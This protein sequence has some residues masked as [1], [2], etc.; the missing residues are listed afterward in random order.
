VLDCADRTAPGLRAHRRK[1]REAQANMILRRTWPALLAALTAAVVR[2]PYLGWGLPHIEEEAYPLK[3]AFTMWGW[4]SGTLQLDPRT[5]GWPALSF[6]LHL[7]LQHLQYAWGRLTGAFAD[8]YDYYVAYLI[9]PSFAVLAARA[10]GLA[11]VAVTVGV[12]FRLAE[13]L[14]GRAAAWLAAGLLVVA[15]LL[16]RHGLL[17]SP[18]ILLLPCV[19]L[20]LTSIVALGEE[21]RRSHYLLAGL[22]IGLGTALKYTPVLLLPALGLVHLLRTRREGTPVL[23]DARPW[24]A[25]SLAA[26]VFMLTSPFTLVD[27]TGLQRDVSYQAAHMGRGHFGQGERPVGYVYY[28][29]R[30]LLPGLGWTGALLGLAGLSLAA[31][32]R[33]GP[34]LTLLIC[35]APFYL[36]L[37]GLRTTFDRYMLPVLPILALGLAGLWSLWEPRLA[38][39]GPRAR[40]LAPWLLGLLACLPAALRS[41]NV[42]AELR[43]PSTQT[44]AE[45]WLEGRLDPVR[46]R[47]A[48]ELYTVELPSADYRRELLEGDLFHR[49][50]PEQQERLLDRTFWS[51]VFIPLYSTY[52][53][54]AALYYDL[55]LY[56]PFR[57]VMTSS[58]VRGRYEAEPARFP[59]QLAFY[60]ALE[61]LGETAEAFMPGDSLRGPEL[62]L[63]RLDEAAWQSLLDL[64]GP[65][66]RDFAAPYHGRIDLGQFRPF[67]ET[68]GRYAYDDGLYDEAEVL[69]HTLY[70]NLDP[71]RQDKLA[72]RLGLLEIQTERW[73]EARGLFERWLALHPNDAGTLANLGLIAQAQGRH[74]EARDYYERAMAADPTGSAADWAGRKL[75][76][77]A[78]ESPLGS[79]PDSPGTER[80]E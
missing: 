16:T 11:A 65:L 78:A 62:H 71:V 39:A 7:V 70:L 1:S 5:A 63:Y 57:Y 36:V 76:E 18:D 55:R 38:T 35:A 69:Y 80:R 31:W 68:V 66:P 42:C 15:P 40:A 72:W 77:L 58:A 75:Q 60:A 54:N 45:T 22:W 24:L 21:G 10:L 2:L 51:Y 32:R 17:I 74:A 30:V 19:T 73:E 8:R 64:E 20:A 13:R 33:R 12:V 26:A 23:R 4:E 37:G 79:S 14:A 67:L 49:L 61:R 59:R 28:A 46:D 50:S 9:D 52:T 29:L 48:L 47:L 25:V 43:R 56:Q 34:W 53:E 6:Y 27:L 44:V 3:K 41:E